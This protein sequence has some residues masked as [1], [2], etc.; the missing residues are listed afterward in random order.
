MTIGAE[1]L[2]KLIR[3]GLGDN[4]M[5]ETIRRAGLCANENDIDWDALLD[6]ALSQGVAYIA[7]DGLRVL[8]EKGIKTGIDSAENEDIRLEWFGEQMKGELEYDSYVNTLSRLARYIDS[9]GAGRLLVLKGFGAGLNYPDPA[10]RS[11]GDID[12]FSLDGR[13]ELIDKLLSHFPGFAMRE[14]E[15]A[16]HSHA[17]FG[18]VSVE[19][20]YSFTSPVGDAVRDLCLEQALAAELKCV[21]PVELSPDATVY[22][23]GADF[24]A[25]F[26]IW[27]MASH[28]T[29]E[30]VNLRQL[31]DWWM[32]L[33]AYSKDVHWDRIMPLL[34]QGRK[35]TFFGVV[36]GAMAEFLG[37]DLALVPSFERR[38]ADEHRFIEFVLSAD[39]LET[40][41]FEAVFKYVRRR[42]NFRI[43]HEQ[44][45]M[46]PLLK[47]TVNYLKRKKI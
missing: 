10:H 9:N 37:M 15:E 23:P 31:C 16:R 46:S 14:N 39:Q 32:F 7:C 11:D 44:H 5:A 29:L 1:V 13:S 17:T 41:G 36:C 22:I 38:E 3:V 8:A 33:R 19:N 47:S 25:V 6:Y 40:K 20:H 21:K 30:K 34:E 42:W 4:T 2:L 43:A 26:Y 12:I 18:G 35:K 24:N 28:F 45:W 27:H